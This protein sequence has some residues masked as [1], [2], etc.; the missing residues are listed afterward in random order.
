MSI[1]SVLGHLMTNEFIAPFNKWGSCSPL[2]L[3][4][5]PIEKTITNEAVKRN[6][7]DEARKCNILLLWL[8][9]DLEG[10]NIAFEVIDVCKGANPRMEVYRARFSALIPRDIF[11]ALRH[12][13]RPNVNANSA[14]EARQE[15]D[16]RIGAAFTRFQTEHLQKR[17]DKLANLTISYGPCQFPTL[18]FVVERCQKIDNFISEK[19]WSIKFEFESMDPED[20]KK[21]LITNFNWQRNCIFDR[22]TCFILYDMCLDNCEATVTNLSQHPTSK[23][24]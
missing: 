6:L 2:E 5:A 1:T 23:Q 21:R 10:E 15:I 13:E 16:L 4:T 7:V 18:G 12:P 3:F 14:V 22:F 11:R 19:F 20:D 8:D 9:C 24:R 17:Y